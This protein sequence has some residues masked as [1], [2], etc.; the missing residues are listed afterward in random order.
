MTPKENLMSRIP[1]TLLASILLTAVVCSPVTASNKNRKGKPGEVDYTA[2]AA[3]RK[4]PE[5]ARELLALA[6]IQA[7]SKGSWERLAVARVYA[8]AGDIAK[9][10]SLVD[11]VLAGKHK[12]SDW[13][14]IG[15][16][17]MAA[18]DWE[19]AKPWFDKVAAA[20]PDDQDWLAEIGGYYLIHGD[21][22]T[23]ARL[24]A[25]SF[26]QDPDSLYNTLRAAL[27]N[28]GK[29]PNP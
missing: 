11:S 26:D 4:G 23:G 18:N 3:G 22:E 27:A 16:V 28:L 15:R 13:I 17:W 21:A 8:A 25:Q 5:V 14:R 2:L 12:E 10:Q 9:A 29:A 24:L 20:K 7:D 19:R 1:R 6:E